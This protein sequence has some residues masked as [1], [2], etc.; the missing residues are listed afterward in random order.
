MATVHLGRLLGPVGFSRTIAVKR[1]HPQYAKD[2]D[3]VSMFLDEANLVSRIRHPNVVPTLDV[4]NSPGSGLL[5]VM[6]YVHG[7]SLSRLARKCREALV[8]IPLRIIAGIMSNVLLGLNAAHD[9]RGNSG[10]L[11]NIVHRDVSPQNILVGADGVARVLDFG[12]AK[13]AGRS[14]TTR[15][16]QVKGKLAYMAPEQIRGKVDRRTDIFAAGIML[17]ELLVGR[18]MFDG[19]NEAQIIGRIANGTLD[20]PVKYMPGIP[21]DVNAIVVRALAPLPDGRFA[22]AKEM[23]MA[24]EKAVGVA[25]P[26]EIGD[27]VESLSKNELATRAE[28][29]E[30]MERASAGLQPTRTDPPPAPFPARPQSGHFNVGT[31]GQASYEVEL[32]ELSSPGTGPGTGSRSG[33]LYGVPPQSNTTAWLLAL[34]LLVVALAG[35]G[36]L[37]FAIVHTKSEADGTAPEP[38][39]IP[40]PPPTAITLP[41]G[42]VSSAGATGSGTT[43]GTTSASA[44]PSAGPRRD[45]AANP[46]AAGAISAEPTAGVASA[47]PSGAASGASSALTAGPVLHPV[48]PLPSAKVKPSCDPPF[49]LDAQGHRHYKPECPLE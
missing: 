37:I 7:D 43:S 9:A 13:A 44:S 48:W 41:K 25:S 30:H 33:P 46:S 24:L 2:P 21:P 12:V 15:E 31:P 22:T 42:A 29:I 32:A 34:V 3:F 5:L 40:S 39:S 28:Y 1:L 35:V 11:L 27:W 19:E 26:S 47:A 20:A 10:E 49:T 14:Q 17:W 4:V 6:E 23:A 16:G 8:P 45:P 36:L 18:R 38:S